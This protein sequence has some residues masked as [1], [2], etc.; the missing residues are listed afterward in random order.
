M[1]YNF[2]KEKLDKLLYD[3][4]RLTGLGTSVWD[5]QVNLLS[6]QPREMCRFCTAVKATPQGRERCRRSDIAICMECAKT[7][8]P[9]THYCHAGLVD[10]AVPIKF[11][12]TVLG[13]IIFGQV[14]DA[15]NDTADIHLKELC[16][17]LK[18]DYNEMLS[19]YG[20]LDSY[21]KER[22][23][24]A[25]AIM[26]RVTAHLWLSEYIEI[27]YSALAQ[28]IDDYIRANLK[29]KISVNSIC[30]R[31][32]IS[33][34]RL[35]DISRQWFKMT[36]S[37]YISFLRVEKAKELLTTTDLSVREVSNAVG[38]CD[39]NYFIKVFKNGTGLPPL[40]YRKGYPFTAV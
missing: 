25:A 9:T 3:F 19:A 24:S 13:Y 22:I 12:D 5:S 15:A 32:F 36:V 8:K 7:G 14:T 34:N 33:K 38:I 2:N 17:E 10:T 21:D 20:E 27:G 1:L 29:E 31:F 28:E 4:Y 23:N 30:T 11:K 35:Y 37:D 6:F 40:K 18:L 39:Y 16:D 26:K